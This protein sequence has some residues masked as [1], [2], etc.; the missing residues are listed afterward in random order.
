MGT[1]HGRRAI[2]RASFL[3]AAAIAIGALAFFSINRSAAQSDS[4]AFAD[5]AEDHFLESEDGDE[6]NT[7]L[8][9][10]FDERSA[11]KPG[12]NGAGEDMLSS[13]PG[14]PS[15]LAHAI[16]LRG[17]AAPFRAW[18]DI[19]GIPGMDAEALAV[20]RRYTNLDTANAVAAAPTIRAAVRNRLQQEDRVRRGY[21]NGSYTGSRLKSLQRLSAGYSDILSATVLL[22]KDAGEVSLIDHLTGYLRYTGDGIL[23]NLVLGDYTIA[24]GQGLALW[25]AY[26][27]S[28]GRETVTSAKRSMSSKG[29][30]SAIHPSASSSEYGYF[31]GVASEFSAGGLKA[32]FFLSSRALDARIDPDSGTFTS[33]DESGLHRSASEISHYR[34]TREEVAGGRVS[35]EL[36]P[37]AAL[38]RAGGTAYASRFGRESASTTPYAFTGNRASMLSADIDAHIPGVN[39]FGEAA[40][41][42]TGACA[43]I[44]GLTVQPFDGAALAILQRNFPADFISLH[45]YAFGERNG[46]TQNENGTYAGMT[47]SLPGRVTLRASYDRYRFP[48]RTATIPQ[49][50]SG[51]EAFAELDW[52]PV[53]R[54]SVAV[55]YRNE[56]KDAKVSAED[57]SGAAI[58]AIVGRRQ[59]GA[60]AEAAF[61]PSDRVSF[62]ARHEI[63]RVDYGGTIQDE[64]GEL[65]TFEGRWSPGPEFQL[66]AR[67]TSFTTSSYDARLYSYEM[68]APGLPNIGLLYGNGLRMAFTLRLTLFPAAVLFV[69]YGQTIQR[70][71]EKIGS[72]WDAV[73]GDRLGKFTAQLDIAWR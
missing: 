5:P 37:G 43:F 6:D 51:K 25:K 38:L 27:F 19:A 54:L 15:P 12:M 50:A 4:S 17:R 14:I 67:I 70:G 48:G 59:R 3:R 65:I 11:E 72:G 61:A 7:P 39:L 33:F 16:V 29:T 49:P 8:A 69:K 45:G 30:A 13:L 26:G 73:E 22:E 44:A 40:R 35:M 41:S 31:R 18:E 1:L 2:P 56:T 58:R 68:D 9:E 34:T 55:R 42:H 60:R 52:R 36:R 46:A 57:E 47:V 23:S 64:R 53:P 10:E 63:V 62:R 21:R 32:L 28:K 20:L 71:A 24:A 66:S